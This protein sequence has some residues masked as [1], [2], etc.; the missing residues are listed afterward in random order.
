MISPQVHEPGDVVIRVEF[1]QFTLSTTCNFTFENYP[2]ITDIPYSDQLTRCVF[3]E[4]DYL[5]DYLFI[6]LR[7]FIEI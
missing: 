4:C 7:V 1:V 2:E 5:C 6:Y 3:K